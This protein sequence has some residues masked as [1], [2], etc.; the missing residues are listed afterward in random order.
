[1]SLYYLTDDDLADAFQFIYTQFQWEEAPA[2]EQETEGVELVRGV[3]EKMQFAYYDTIFDKAAYLFLEV[4]IGHPFSNGNK[5]LALVLALVFLLYNHYLFD[6]TRSK[7]GYKELLTIS[8]PEIKQWQ[9]YEEF[10]GIDCALY[11][12]ATIV[13]RHHEEGYDAPQMRERLTAFFQDIFSY[14]PQFA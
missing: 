6:A 12:V 1:M 5:R 2:Y 8:F 11:N 14:T 13:A 3:I 10:S 9:D 4:I 7:E